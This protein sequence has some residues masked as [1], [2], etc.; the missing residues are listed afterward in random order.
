[1]IQLEDDLQ[2][3]KPIETKTDSNKPVVSESI[4]T[5][6]DITTN[7]A[8]VSQ[9]ADVIDI[10]SDSED[11]FIESTK[12][13]MEDSSTVV[14]KICNIDADDASELISQGIPV[15][16]ESSLSQFQSFIVDSEKEAGK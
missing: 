13:R 12:S 1:M 3:S 4:T 2:P 9:G 14:E 7:T 8:N 16:S 15:V 10:D 5:H 6:T 11:E